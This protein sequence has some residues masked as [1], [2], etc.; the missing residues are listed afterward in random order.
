MRSTLT[1]L[2]RYEWPLLAL[3]AMSGWA[4]SALGWNGGWP[5]AVYGLWQLLQAARFHGGRAPWPVGY[6]PT[7]W[8][9]QQWQQR[10]QQRR[11]ERRTTRFEHQQRMLDA[12]PQGVVE[13][14]AEG[15]IVWFNTAAARLL[16]LKKDDR[17]KPIQRL[18]RLPEFVRWLEHDREDVLDL[19]MPQARLKVLRF[20]RRRLM[21]ASLLLVDDVTEEHDL[22][23]VRR[24][25][26]AN[27]S[28]ELRT[29]VT[30]FRGYLE[31][32]LT[33]DD[34]A[35]RPWRGALDQMAQ[36]AERMHRIIEDLLTLSAIERHQGDGQEQTLDLM[37]LFEQLAEEARHLSQG[38]HELTFTV[39][40]PAGLRGDATLVRSIFSNLITNALRYTPEGGR[41]EVCWFVRD[42]GEGVFEVLDTGIGIPREHIPRLTERFYRLD[43]ARSRDSGGTGLGLA[44][45]KHALEQHDGRLEIESTPQVGSVFRA[46]FPAKRLVTE[47]S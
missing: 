1:E 42:T 39:S 13:L 20:R 26:V 36:Q 22:A 4:F 37:Q 2:L 25:F 40:Q 3:A 44:I 31:T 9:Y 19:T 35:L 15:S 32:L 38:R 12:L 45:V 17:G 28:H 7:L 29:P 46:V 11:L 16:G 33:L 14:S 21:D 5:W 18:V 23:Q 41:V 8:Q 30:V 34:A 27:A 47:V 43:T 24:A 6:W 10:R